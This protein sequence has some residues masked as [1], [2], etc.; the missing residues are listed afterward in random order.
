MSNKTE[1]PTVYVVVLYEY[2]SPEIVAVFTDRPAAEDHARRLND[3]AHEERAALP[4]P[5]TWIGPWPLRQD[6]HY[7][8]AAPLIAQHNPSPPDPSE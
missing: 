3:A 8:E 4:R 7:V 2:A 1:L 5:S 6:G